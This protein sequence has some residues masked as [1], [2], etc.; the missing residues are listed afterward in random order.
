[1]KVLAERR[2][3]FGV[4]GAVAEVTV[5]YAVPDVQDFVL[6]AYEIGGPTEKTPQ[7]KVERNQLMALVAVLGVSDIL[8]GCGPGNRQETA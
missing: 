1:V 5:D 4:R 6:Y 3:K 7:G 8:H 2:R